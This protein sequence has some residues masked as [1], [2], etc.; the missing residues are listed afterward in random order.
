MS[1][2]L[3]EHSHSTRHTV[4]ELHNHQ[5]LAAWKEF[6]A[7]LETSD[8]P[9]EDVSE[10]WAAA[11]FVSPYIDPYTP[12]SWPDPWHLILDSKWDDLAISLGML[13]TLQLT[14][15]FCESI[16]QIAMVKLPYEKHNRYPLIVNNDKV[17]N[18]EYKSV[19]GLD[20]IRNAGFSIIWS[21]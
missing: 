19:V 11:P 21:R 10:L 15:R 14:D 20:S 13:Y 12:T 18:F 16:F 6:R 2:D 9:L 8:R 17:L 3:L 5:R 7:T 1:R 4:F